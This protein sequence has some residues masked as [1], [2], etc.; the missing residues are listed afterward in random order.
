MT[1]QM[2]TIR[3]YI[4]L[5]MHLMWLTTFLPQKGKIQLQFSKKK[6]CGDES[7]KVIFPKKFCGKFQID[8]N[9]CFIL[10]VYHLKEKLQI[11][12][13]MHISSTNSLSVGLT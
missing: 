3:Y 10:K 7:S 4:S 1:T 9:K 11:R 12:S 2:H 6:Y 13:K 8:N 5:Q